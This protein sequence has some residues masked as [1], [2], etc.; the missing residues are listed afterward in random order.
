MKEALSLCRK[1]SNKV[2]KTWS[3][4]LI[5]VISSTFKTFVSTENIY[6]FKRQSTY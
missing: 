6:S 4:R 1:I 5:R 2:Q 3:K